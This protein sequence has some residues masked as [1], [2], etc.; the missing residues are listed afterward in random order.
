MARDFSRVAYVLVQYAKIGESR[1]LHLTS[2]MTPL[3]VEHLDIVTQNFETKFC[4][5]NSLIII[6]ITLDNVITIDDII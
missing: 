1:R 4:N 6:P 2:I 3:F 5:V